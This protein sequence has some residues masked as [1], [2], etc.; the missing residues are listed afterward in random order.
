MNS[1]MT[2]APWERMMG[3]WVLRPNVSA[4]ISAQN[5]KSGKVY[6]PKSVH[7]SWMMTLGQTL[8]W[9]LA[10]LIMIRALSLFFQLKWMKMMRKKEK[11]IRKRRKNR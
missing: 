3:D 8:A 1:M 5:K 7:L 2:C 6:G 10:I 9:I 4:G 11:R